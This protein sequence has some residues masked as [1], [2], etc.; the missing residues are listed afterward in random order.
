MFH[1]IPIDKSGHTALF[2]LHHISNLIG[3][4]MKQSTYDLKSIKMPRLAGVGLRTLVALMENPLSRGLVIS[5]LLGNFG[6]AKLRK[7]SLNEPPT[8]YPHWD[9]KAEPASSFN[10]TS[11]AKTR[12]P[13]GRGFAFT[14]TRD[15]AEAYQSGA[16]TPEII[17]EQA[18]TAIE[19]SNAFTPA[20]RAI[21]ACQSDDVIKQARASAERWRAGKPLSIFDGVP[22]AVKDEM[23]MVPYGTTWGTSFLGKTPA[24]ADS[25]VVAR[26]RAAGAL[27]IGKANMHEIGIG[28]TGLNPH[29]G[30]TRN[31]YNPRHF[32]G[33]SSSGSAAAVAAGLCPAAISADGGGSIRNPAGFCGVYG[34]KATFGRVSEFSS[35]VLDW[36]VAHNG[37]IAATAEDTALMYA[38]I[39]G[40]DPKDLHTLNQPPV[41]LDGFD[42]FDLGDLKIGIFTPWFEH[43]S[44]AMVEGC[45]KM[46]SAFQSMGAQVLEIEIPELEAAHIAHTITIA[47]E[48]FTVLAHEYAEHRSDFSLEIR[49]DLALAR[50]LTAFD[51]LQAQRVRTRALAHFR[52]VME[53]VDVII[54]PTSGCTAPMIPPDALPDG[55][56][57]LTTLTEIMRFATPANLTGLPAISFPAGY[58]T[59]GLPIGCQL[60]G[61]AWEEH[62]LLRLAHAAEQ[63]VERQKPQIYY[64]LLQ[65]K[66]ETGL[67]NQEAV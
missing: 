18:L 53:E 25:T 57:D 63:V 36:S 6:I 44:P 62:V 16:T 7:L 61:R 64:R 55:E 31:P 56:S 26:M 46:V 43:A 38:V 14:T 50:S 17:A 65:D 34:L 48:M 1:R 12:R 9:K 20:L 2:K 21:I 8:L 47:A 10:L 3:G 45:R 27:L 66:A 30:D 60:M 67:D 22:V 37:P 19:D 4:K 58:S 11:W 41:R 40:P 49:T 51:Y 59:D 13:G 42:N 39:A 24:P 15:Y 52:R 35:A 32:S 23:D 54:T 5:R 33:G 29:H 28:V